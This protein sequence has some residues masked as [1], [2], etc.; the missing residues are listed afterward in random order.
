MSWNPFTRITALEHQVLY[1]QRALGDVMTA[2]NVSKPK[3]TDEEK[4]AR[5][6]EQQRAYYARQ[7]IK[8]KQ[9]GYQQAY[10]DRKKAEK[11]SAGGTA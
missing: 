6:R 11:M 3:V 1:L 5:R 7:V 8:E 2:L 4:L 10:R 9:R